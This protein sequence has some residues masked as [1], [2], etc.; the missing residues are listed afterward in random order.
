MQCD[1]IGSSVV[2]VVVFIA[3][4]ASSAAAGRKGDINSS[5]ICYLFLFSCLSI[6]NEYRKEIYRISVAAFSDTKDDNTTQTI[7]I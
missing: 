2:V 3:D 4:A 1:G 6:T 7:V 5:P